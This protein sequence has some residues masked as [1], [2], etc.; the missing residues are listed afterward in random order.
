MEARELS[1]Q[2]GSQFH[3]SGDM[4]TISPPRLARNCQ[5][6]SFHKVVK[7]KMAEHFL[8]LLL[9]HKKMEDHFDDLKLVLDHPA[10]MV[11]VFSGYS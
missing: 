4:L 7:H 1:I 3:L 9:P 10:A 5:V 6:L 11:V 2:M 8:G